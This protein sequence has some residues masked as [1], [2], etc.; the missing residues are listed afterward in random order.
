[1]NQSAFA[2]AL[3]DS[4]RPVPEGLV[5]WNE[6]RVEARFAVY[7]NNVVASLIDALA[8]TYPVVQ[9]LVGARF[10]RA[11][12]REWIADHPPRSPVLAHYGEGFPG[13]IAG[14]APAAGVP[15]LPDV[16]RLEWAY[17]QSFHAADAAPLAP[18]ALAAALA[19]P[20]HLPGLRLAL[21]PSVRTLASGYAIVSLWGAHQEERIDALPDPDRA[22]AAL[23][24]RPALQVHVVAI[25]AGTHA[26]VCALQRGAPLGEAAQAGADT[27]VDFDLT[28]ALGVLLRYQAVQEMVR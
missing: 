5:V 24:L 7:R 6:S 14:F 28:R 10:F 9:R 4:T 26:L 20:E 11:M 13:F 22:E 27:A 23:L 12:A 21:H 19:T 16:A 15:Y 8:D 17:V 1:M 18:A 2:H 25:D 3:L